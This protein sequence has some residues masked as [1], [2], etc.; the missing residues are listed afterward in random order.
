[1]RQWYYVRSGKQVGP[2]EE[3]VLRSLF[4]EERLPPDTY[5]WTDGM[6]DW[7][8]AHTFEDLV[9][10]SVEPERFP[11][12]F[13]HDH[14]GTSAEEEPA[15]PSPKESSRP[16]SRPEV[17]PW[18]RYW[19]RYIDFFLYAFF[20]GIFLATFYERAFSWSNFTFGVMF[21]LSYAFVEPIL[22]SSFGTTPGKALFRIR[23]C[24][25]DG[26]RLTYRQALERSLKVY[27][28][29][30][31][32]GIPILAFFLHIRA[33]SNLMTDG[34]TSWDRE[35]GSVVEHGKLSPARS[36]VILSIILTMLLVVG[37]SERNSW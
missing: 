10:S 30:E 1:M 19:A 18:H 36:L 31:G 26:S 2:L 16:S 22:L 12:P 32:I 27:L 6:Q 35:G 13:P 7:M 28:R 3:A 14:P 4:D 15:G 5:V 25:R 29:A 34:I 24:N 20:G 9:P 37:W 11:P 8:P 21:L 23:L 17:H 33:Y